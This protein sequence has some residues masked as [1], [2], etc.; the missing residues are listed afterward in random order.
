MSR[1]TVN[2]SKK[3]ISKNSNFSGILK[4]S[5]GILKENENCRFLRRDAKFILR[6]YP[7]FVKHPNYYSVILK[8]NV[9]LV[10][11]T[12]IFCKGFLLIF[13]PAMY[14]KIFPLHV[15]SFRLRS[16][17]LQASWLPYRHT[18][19]SLFGGGGNMKENEIINYFN[20]IKT[21]L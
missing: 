21:L 20:F 1:I 4:V 10:R 12:A 15:A 9:Y 17:T 7:G 16:T 11:N 2:P 19:C 14:E 5:A 6:F 13:L 8:E 18:G 3:K